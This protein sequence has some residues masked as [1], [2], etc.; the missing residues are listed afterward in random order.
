MVITL[1]TLNLYCVELIGKIKPL[2]GIPK[3]GGILPRKITSETPLKHGDIIKTGKSASAQVIYNDGS[4]ILIK[5]SST[6]VLKKNRITIKR[7]NSVLKFEKKNKKFRI[8][9][10]VVLMGLL[11]TELE[12]SIPEKN[13]SIIKL[14]K[15]KIWLKATL[16]NKKKL[17]LSQGHTV[18]ITDKGIIE[19]SIK[20]ET[21]VQ[22]STNTSVVEDQSDNITDDDNMEMDGEYSF[23]II[24]LVLNLPY[25]L[26]I[27]GYSKYNGK[28]LKFET[29]V[30]FEFTK[31]EEGTYE[32][33]ILANGIE[34]TF[35]ITVTPK[36]PRQQKAIK[37]V[38]KAIIPFICGL[39]DTSNSQERLNHLKFTMIHDGKR[40]P[41]YYMDPKTKDHFGSVIYLQ[42]M[43][44]I[45]G[46]VFYLPKG[47][48]EYP[49]VELEYTGNLPVKL[50]KQTV[51]FNK[52]DRIYKVEF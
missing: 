8:V 48:E 22:K 47:I 6:V 37:Y 41:L 21:L 3:F 24:T 33:T 50:K 11:G 10:P 17:V 30:P 15:G 19:D 13:V 12:V 43:D 1:T 38:H 34:N 26:F 45:T 2:T 23:K 40:T 35:P 46:N 51:K 18:K 32:I 31:L 7:G 27:D 49:E 20:T 4:I 44:L 36:N 42:G 5:S 14:N 16:G 52:N 25:R 29:P 9:T 39:S 28:D